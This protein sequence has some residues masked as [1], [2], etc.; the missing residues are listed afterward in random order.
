MF[1]GQAYLQQRQFDRAREEFQRAVDLSNGAAFA[2]GLL[3]HCQALAGEKNEALR[4]LEKLQAIAP[5]KY[6]SPDFPAWVHLG[7]GNLEE[8]FQ[9]LGAAYDKRSNWL[10]WLQPDPRYDGLRGDPRFQQ[11][12]NHVGLVRG[13]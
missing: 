5:E 11:L 10:A 6:V 4:L 12:L 8:T 1:L 7:L 13:V 9:L 3:G 2:L